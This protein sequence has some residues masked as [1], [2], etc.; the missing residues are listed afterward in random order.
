M[1]GSAK[2]FAPAADVPE[3]ARKGEVAKGF[4]SPF[5]RGFFGILEA[6]VF[7][8]TDHG[9]VSPGQWTGSGA[10]DRMH[11]LSPTLPVRVINGAFDCLN[12]EFESATATGNAGGDAQMA[13]I[14]PVPTGEVWR[15]YAGSIVTDDAG[16]ASDLDAQGVFDAA[17]IAAHCIIPLINPG[18][19]ITLPALASTYLNIPYLGTGINNVTMGTLNGFVDVPAGYYYGARIGV[20]VAIPNTKT[21]VVHVPVKK[22]KLEV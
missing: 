2:G 19:N 7:K 4:L 18:V 16:T 1:G 15:C 11:V 21:V 12:V 14:G 5:S 20:D 3:G 22:Y 13:V 8:L 17:T 9:T 10:M 6:V